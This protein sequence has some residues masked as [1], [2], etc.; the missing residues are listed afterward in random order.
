MKWE[1]LDQCHGAIHVA[2]VYDNRLEKKL[3]YREYF[4]IK[5]EYSLIDIPT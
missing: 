2:F 3:L 4:K 5:S 1:I